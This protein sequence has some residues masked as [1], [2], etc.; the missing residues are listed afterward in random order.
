MV[1]LFSPDFLGSLCRQE[2]IARRGLRQAHRK[3]KNPP[4]A[5]SANF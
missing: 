5:D 4:N 3:K 2:F 1:S